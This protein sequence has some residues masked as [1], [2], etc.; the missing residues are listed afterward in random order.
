M[1]VSPRS[2]SAILD[3]LRIEKVRW[4][5]ELD[6]VDFLNRVVDLSKLPSHDRRHSN[7]NGDVW[8]HRV[9]NDDWDNDWIYGDRRLDFLGCSDETFLEFLRQ[10]VHP[11]VRPNTPEAEA[12]AGKINAILKNDGVELV[13]EA[14]IFGRPEYVARPVTSARIHLQQARAAADVLN[15][16]WMNKEIAR[17]ERAID[18]DPDDALRGAKDLVESCCKSILEKRGIVVSSSDDISDL[19]RK[20]LKELKLAVDDIKDTVR[21][22]NDIKAILGSLS[23]IPNRLASLRNEYGTGHGRAGDYKGLQP[24]HAR[25]AVMAASAFAIFITETFRE[26]QVRGPTSGAAT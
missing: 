1:K 22:A 14:S 23:N 19:T 12:L 11:V 10:L 7:M 8:Q 21:A 17:I 9:M 5:G 6:E 24:R 4:W 2:R 26:Q 13:Q 3:G 25:L 20:T 18:V 16:I 15:A